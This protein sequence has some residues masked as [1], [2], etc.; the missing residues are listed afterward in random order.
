MHNHGCSGVFPVS[1]VPRTQL[2]KCNKEG[3]NST[4]W[5]CNLNT[6][7]VKHCC[8]VFLHLYYFYLLSLLCKIDQQKSEKMFSGM[9]VSV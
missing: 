9:K 5:Y 2:S 1:T 8:A 4:C 6:W 3:R 7:S